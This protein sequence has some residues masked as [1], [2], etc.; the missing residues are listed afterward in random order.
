MY[1]IYIKWYVQVIV[2]QVNLHDRVL[3][4]FKTS[5][6]KNKNMEATK[7]FTQYVT[8]TDLDTKVNCGE[9]IFEIYSDFM[10]RAQSENLLLSQI[11]WSFWQSNTWILMMKWVVSSEERLNAF[12]NL[13]RPV[14]YES[15]VQNRNT[16]SSLLDIGVAGLIQLY[17]ITIPLLELHKD[18]YGRIRRK[19]ENAFVECF[20]GF[21]IERCDPFEA[22]SICLLQCEAVVQRCMESLSRLDEGKREDIVTALQRKPVEKTL[23]LLEYVQNQKTQRRLI[24]SLIERL[25]E[26]FTQNIFSFSTWQKLINILLEICIELGEERL[27][28]KA[29]EL[30]SQFKEALDKKRQNFKKDY[31][32]WLEFAELQLELLRGNA[33][34]VLDSEEDSLN[35]LFYKALIYLNRDDIES[36]EK[37]EELYERYIEREE[38]CPAY[39][40]YFVACVRICTHPKSVEKE[41]TLYL[42]KAKA[43]VASIREKYTLTLYEEMIV[44]SNELF[45]YAT[46]KDNMEFWKASGNLPESL[47]YECSCAQYIVQMYAFGGEKKKAE[48]YLDELIERYGQTDLLLQLEHDIKENGEKNR[49]EM[50]KGVAIVDDE[51]KRLRHAVNRIKSLSERDCALV[52][53]Q[54]DSFENPKE[55]HLLYMVLNAVHKMSQ[56][57]DY[58][59]YDSNTANENTYNKFIQIFF[60]QAQK[61]VWDF[62]IKDQTQ[63]GS[64]TGQ[65][66]NKRQSTGSL[67][68]AIYHNT[69]MVSIVEGIKLD[70]IDNDRIEEH[71]RKIAGY[72]YVYA[73]TAFLLIF[74]DT[75]DPMKM[76]NEYETRVLKRIKN[77]TKDEK[78]HITEQIPLENI[79]LIKQDIGP[80]PLYMCMT[81]HECNSTGQRFNLYHI[82]VDIRKQA[83]KEEAVSA[84][85]LTKK[86]RGKKLSTS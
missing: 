74:A 6:E 28:D 71:I 24:D 77:E 72:D 46:L 79:E 37:A 9:Q 67:D 25:D 41:K 75:S 76:W 70:G 32:D 33:Q 23:F 35:V 48:E 49:F 80:N 52:R 21:Q 12:L 36:L 17:L 62:Y 43:A 15:I 40:N 47:K 3:E 30:L 66:M 60:D 57:S 61:E 78:W 29:S 42:Q 38:C 73:E 27:V 14:E 10:R 44:C 50:P 69:S 82:M 45:L 31:V 54:K 20:L 19:I 83:A 85:S 13:L 2:P 5:F 4:H 55:A 59:M 11:D 84:R 86:G 7:Y 56:Y 1:R 63:E 68:L 16:T 26:D 81:V 64:A 22:E 53:L 51:I 8:L 58:V 34:K 65:L 18:V 39:I